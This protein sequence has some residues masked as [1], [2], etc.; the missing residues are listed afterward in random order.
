MR[1]FRSHVHSTD[2]CVFA[3]ERNQLISR[4]DPLVSV[5]DHC[6]LSHG[7]QSGVRNVGA[8]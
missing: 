1:L 7:I 5:A 2:G 6:D 3:Y 4:A 8:V